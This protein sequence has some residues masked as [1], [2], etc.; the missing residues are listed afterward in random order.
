MNQL[1]VS[2]KGVCMCESAQCV[3]EQ[4]QHRRASQSTQHVGQRSPYGPRQAVQAFCSSTNTDSNL[5]RFSQSGLIS[6][7]EID[8]VDSDHG[9]D[10]VDAPYGDDLVASDV[11]VYKK[12]Q[13]GKR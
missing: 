8:L 5:T 7:T 11:L 1:T 10:L 3:A 12:K 6:S 13:V 9:I 4:R 2:I